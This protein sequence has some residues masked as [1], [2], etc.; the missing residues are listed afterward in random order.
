MDYLKPPSLLRCPNVIWAGVNAIQNL[1]KEVRALNGSKVLLVS[2]PG[3]VKAGLAKKAEDILQTEKI[4]YQLFSDVEPEPSIATA[5]KC[6]G[7]ARQ[8]GADIIIGVGGGSAIDVA[9]SAAIC[10]K[11]GNSIRDY[12]GLDNVPGRGLPMIAIPTT[13]GTGSEVTPALVLS[14]QVDHTKKSAWSRYVLVDSAIVDPLMTLSMPPHVTADTGTDAISHAIEAFVS[15]RANPF[16]DALALDSIRLIG[17]NLRKAYANGNDL[18]AREKMAYGALLAGIAFGSSGLGC[19]A[20]LG[21]PFTSFYGHSH[22]KAMGI[23]MPG[24]MRFNALAN[25]EK[26][27]RIAEAMGEEIYGLSLREAALKAAD[28]VE[29]LVNDVGIATRISAYNIPESRLPEMAEL[30]VTPN[31]RLLVS[32]PRR[33]GVP[34]ALEVYK[35]IY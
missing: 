19:I 25:E 4:P 33:M 22:G 11:K 7:F 28:A 21:Y 9:K 27:S 14:D 1:G 32:N 30:A 3:V 13:A 8:M 23:V 6:I 24:S 12:L 5:D 18:E 20:A 31:A 15:V 34:E 2:D 10:G 29:L 17:A 35:Q 26:F 16:S